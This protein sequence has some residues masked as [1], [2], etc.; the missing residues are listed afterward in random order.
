MALTKVS[1]GLMKPDNTSALAY[2]SQLGTTS[3][4]GAA[5]GF[6]VRTNYY[7]SNVTAGSGATFKFT[8]VTTLGKAG[9]VPN[10]DGYFYD[11]VGRQFAIDSDTVYITQ[12]GGVGDWNGSTGTDNSSVV[13]AVTNLFVSGGIDVLR[14]PNGNFMS[15]ASLGEINTTIRVVGSEALTSILT[16]IN[17]DGIIHR[18]YSVLEH[19]TIDGND[20]TSGSYTGANIKYQCR[21][22]DINVT[23]FA[24]G[25]IATSS[26]KSIDKAFIHQ[27]GVGL[28]IDGGAGFTDSV[29]FAN[30]WLNN[31]VIGC[32]EIGSQA[33]NISFR[34]VF[35]Q[36]NNVHYSFLGSGRYARYNC[37]EEQAGN[38]EGL[39]T[40][41]W[42]DPDTTTT[43]AVDVA[44]LIGT[45]F[46]IAS[47]SYWPVCGVACLSPT[48]RTG[49]TVDGGEH[50]YYTRSGTTLT[51]QARAQ[52]GTTA[53]THASGATIYVVPFNTAIGGSALLSDTNHHNSGVAQ[54]ASNVIR[55]TRA[56]HQLYSYQGEVRDT[57]R[58][59]YVTST[60][61]NFSMNGADFGFLAT[62]TDGVAG[63]V[64]EVRLA[65][66]VNW[67]NNFS[68]QLLTISGIVN[69]IAS[70]TDVGGTYRYGSYRVEFTVHKPGT[71]SGAA[72]LVVGAVTQTTITESAGW[73]T[74]P[75]VTIA[76]S[77]DEYG[78]VISGNCDA[79]GGAFAHIT[80]SGS[81]KYL[82]SE[83][84]WL[85]EAQVV[86]P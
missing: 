36:A 25:V 57:T 29:E 15:T 43:S 47:D 22:S 28:V 27:N 85:G 78:V 42:T 58:R 39:V 24:T 14:I 54:A 53:A 75:V 32:Q 23:G 41:P 69:F 59:N 55:I 33:L 46:T 62:L 7:D 1:S 34:N 9:N 17:C 50:I 8:G 60:D 52:T 20:Y 30:I 3:F 48:G 4:V 5:T 77:T 66:L 18:F 70:R 40:T 84:Y 31:N 82:L 16:F 79:S 83:H 37:W 86:L 12:F 21:Y 38:K 65:D 76:A 10:G 44:D 26:L 67:E 80:C 61:G 71:S 19:L 13:T 73:T 45:T 35:A 68:S 51:I 6:T 81:L 63:E 72:A 74:S 49:K 11:L 2:T 64:C 56:H